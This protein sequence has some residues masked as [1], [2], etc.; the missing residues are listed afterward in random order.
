MVN[1]MLARVVPQ[2]TCSVPPLAV[3]SIE[4]VSWSAAFAGLP[5]GARLWQAREGWRD[6]RVVDGGG[7]ENRCTR[8]GI[9]G[10][11][12]SPSAIRRLSVTH[13]SG[14]HQIPLF[15]GDRIEHLKDSNPLEEPR[16]A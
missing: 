8:K 10:S 11:N 7:L 14:G 6:G 3:S 1:G 15:S 4:I 9:G 2:S 16:A 5:A 12:P 13:P